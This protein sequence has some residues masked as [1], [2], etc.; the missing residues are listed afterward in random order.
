MVKS[1]LNVV[2][3]NPNRSLWTAQSRIRPAY[4]AM[5]AAISTLS[6]MLAAISKPPRCIA[7]HT[8]MLQLSM[9]LY[10]SAVSEH[11]G[12]LYIHAPWRELG[13]V[14]VSEQLASAMDS[15]IVVAVVRL[16]KYRLLAVR[17]IDREKL[18]STGVHKRLVS[19]L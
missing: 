7:H 8:H 2:H 15:S 9:D 19:R 10:K 12:Q 16:C 11:D 6:S 5:L 13:T 1:K 4:P 17:L 14:V 18:L 3:I